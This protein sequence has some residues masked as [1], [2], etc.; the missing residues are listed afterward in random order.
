[1]GRSQNWRNVTPLE[2]RWTGGVALDPRSSARGGRLCEQR[3]TTV[4]G[5]ALGPQYAPPRGRQGPAS[6]V[7]H[8]PPEVVPA[9]LE[10]T[11]ASD[12]YNGDGKV[13][14]ALRAAAYVSW[15]IVTSLG[16]PSE[17]GLRA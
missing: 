17:T 12:T 4:V 1:M 8:L 9:V 10:R 7:W 3:S 14:S 13:Y 2:S 11:L 6:P 15:G 5:T 16:A